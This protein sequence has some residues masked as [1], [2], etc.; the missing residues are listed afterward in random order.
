MNESKHQPKLEF[1][2]NGKR[3]IL[4]EASHPRTFYGIRPEAEFIEDNARWIEGALTF[5]KTLHT[6]LLLVTMYNPQVSEDVKAWINSEIVPET[7]LRTR[8]ECNSWSELREY[9]KEG[10][11]FLTTRE[12]ALLADSV[13]LGKTI[14]AIAAAQIGPERRLVVCPNSLKGWW[15]DQ[16]SKHCPG[17]RIVVCGQGRKAFPNDINWQTFGDWTVV[18]W[19]AVRNLSTLGK[20]R[21]VTWDVIIADEAHRIKNRKTK[22]AKALKQLKTHQRWALTATPYANL[23]SDLFSILQ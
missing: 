19:E 6:A 11:T 20:L 8:V 7:S 9:Q 2:T 17:H 4:R 13:G 14:Q 1:S 18:H 15:H 3:L 10:V 5:P 12:S 21:R 16:I 22:T 23:P